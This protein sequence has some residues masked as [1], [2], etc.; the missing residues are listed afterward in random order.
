MEIV[1]ELV[2][3]YIFGK[4]LIN[5]LGSVGKKIDGIFEKRIDKKD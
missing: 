2:L 5:L 1:I 3:I 4:V